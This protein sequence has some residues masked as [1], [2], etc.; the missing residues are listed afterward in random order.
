VRRLGALVE[1][2][3][4][5]GIRVQERLVDGEP[6]DSILRAARRHGADV[7]VIGTHGRS[8]LGRWFMG[9][10][11]SRLVQISP[12]PVLTVKGSA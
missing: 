2:A 6:A 8:G 7:I 3:R 10:V 4:R 1:K 11:A 5:A 9:S 12:F